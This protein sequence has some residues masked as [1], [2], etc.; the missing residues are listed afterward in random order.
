MCEAASL[1]LA[2]SFLQASPNLVIRV[3]DGAVDVEARSVRVGDLL[4][5]VAEKTGMKVI[6]D[7]HRPSDLVTVSLK[8]RTQLE[9][10]LAILQG[11]NVNYA[12]TTDVT[13][14]RITTLIVTGPG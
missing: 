8:H 6:Y 10:V 4:D 13:Q 14:R 12:L 5:R 1:L 3:S 11:L 9:A 7:G 2:V